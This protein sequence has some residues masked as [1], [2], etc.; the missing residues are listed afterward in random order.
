M[1]ETESDESDEEDRDI[2]MDAQ[3]SR[4]GDFKWKDLDVYEQ[5]CLSQL[6]DEAFLSDIVNSLFSH[7]PSGIG[8]R[9]AITLLAEV[10]NLLIIRWPMY[11]IK[12]FGLLLYNLTIPDSATGAHNFVQE[13][14]SVWKSGTVSQEI[15]KL[16]LA[17]SSSRIVSYILSK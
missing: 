8:R 3:E 9:T 17:S 13:L 6:H 15:G 7:Q 2:D 5:D 1:I 11:K 16:P 14:W 4:G 10:F 12:I